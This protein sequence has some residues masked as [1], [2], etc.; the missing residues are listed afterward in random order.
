MNCLMLINAFHSVVNIAFSSSQFTISFF[1]FLN[2]D[3]RETIL[4]LQGGVENIFRG[5]GSIWKSL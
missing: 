3:L 5:G 2:F 4:C 1:F